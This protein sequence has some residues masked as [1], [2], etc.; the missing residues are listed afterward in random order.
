MT[1]RFVI[2]PHSVRSGVE[3]VEVFVGDQFVGA[4]YPGDRDDE[5]RFVSKHLL[6]ATLNETFP[7]MVQVF[8]SLGG[9]RQ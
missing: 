3:M 7:P 6:S 5:V 2:K 8:L 4:F 9:S 1:M